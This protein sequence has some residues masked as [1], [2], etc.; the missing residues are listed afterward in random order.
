MTAEL[1]QI[2]AGNLVAKIQQHFG[3]PAHA[4]AADA[5]EMY[6]LNFGKHGLL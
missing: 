5:Y 4:D 3:N 2:G 6:P 1:L